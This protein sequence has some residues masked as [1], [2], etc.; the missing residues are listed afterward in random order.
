MSRSLVIGDT[1]QLS[2]YFPKSYERISSR[3][4]DVNK[5]KSSKYD[6]VYITFAEQRTFL[7]LNEEDYFDV[8]VKYTLNLI[9]KIKNHV[10]RVIIYST[11]ELWNNYHGEVSINDKY[12]YNYSPYIKSK[13]IL[14]E[15]I[16]EKKYEYKNVHI[17]Y[18]FNFNSPTRKS[19]FLFY[20]IFDSLINKKINSIGNI[21]FFRDI[22]HPSIIVKESI[23]TQTDKLVGSGELINI[24]DYVSKIFDIHN[25]N[26]K[27]YLLF[28]VENNLKTIRNNYYSSYKYSNYE[29]LLYLTKK[30]I[31]EYKIS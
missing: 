17:I 18:P 30:D 28:D 11:S 13:E 20:K 21:N 4:I 14:S 29:E 25:M 19:G 15:K 6:S 26:Y 24:E 12:N 3:N 2:F 23:N 10:N 31:D 7:N 5:I 1:S 8:N 16:N 9:D 27:E 22:I